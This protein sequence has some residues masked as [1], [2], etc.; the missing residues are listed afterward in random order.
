MW[1]PTREPLPVVGVRLWRRQGNLIQ[2]RKVAQRDKGRES[3]SPGPSA[4]SNREQRTPQPRSLHIPP[5]PG[6]S[7]TGGGASL[8]AALTHFPAASA[9]TALI[10]IVRTAPSYGPRC[11]SFSTR[12]QLRLSSLS[13]QGRVPISYRAQGRGDGGWSW[14]GGPAPPLTELGKSAWASSAAPPLPRAALG[15]TA[16]VA[17]PLDQGTG[18]IGG[19]GPLLAYP[20]VVGSGGVKTCCLAAVSPPPC[21]GRSKGRVRSAS[22]RLQ[23]CAGTGWVVGRATGRSWPPFRSPQ[24]PGA[25]PSGFG[26]LDSAGRSRWRIILAHNLEAPGSTTP[27]GPATQGLVRFLQTHRFWERGASRQEDAEFLMTGPVSVHSLV[28]GGRGGTPTRSRCSLQRCSSGPVR[29]L[30]CLCMLWSR[31]YATCMS[32]SAA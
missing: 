8:G 25:Q 3:G 4:A 6:S 26:P 7:R 20:E 9:G 13:A 24:H 23:G 12:A 15:G 14:R 10:P 17:C 5:R 27:S 28:P 16:C 22:A 30:G 32:L 29:D 21:P 31:E 2:V 19:V 11:R 18:A 1:S